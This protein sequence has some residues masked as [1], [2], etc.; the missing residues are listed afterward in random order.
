[1]TRRS[2]GARAAS[3]YIGN[4]G[5]WNVE[6]TG[7]YSGAGTSDIVWE[8]QTSGVTY[9]WTMANGTRASSTLLG[10]LAGWSGQ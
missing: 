5:G 1:M 8:N 7:D 2:T 9:Q 4:L 6:G 10:S 3:V